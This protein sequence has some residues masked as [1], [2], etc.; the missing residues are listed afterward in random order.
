MLTQ[1]TFVVDYLKRRKGTGNE[2]QVKTLDDILSHLSLLGKSDEYKRRMADRLRSHPRIQWIPDPN[3]SEQ[4]WRSGT[5]VHRPLIPGVR[6]KESLVAYLR[7]RAAATVPGADPS[8]VDEN[9]DPRGLSVKDLKDGWPDC[10]EDVAALEKAHR[11]LVVRTKKDNHPRLVWAD[12]PEEAEP[13]EPDYGVWFHRVELPAK[14]DIGRRLKDVGQKSSSEDP[15]PKVVQQSKT[16]KKRV[17]KR[18]GKLTNI[19]MEKLLKNYS[20]YTKP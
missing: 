11:I 12:D 15:K 19:H 17:Q 13:V 1:L 18:P 9:E 16:V 7:K 2:P 8:K 3:L 14:S 4:T 6:D 20:E 10:E 5:Y